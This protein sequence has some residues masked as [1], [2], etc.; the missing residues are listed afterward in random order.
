MT[1]S[2][3]QLLDELMRILNYDNLTDRQLRV[4]LFESS[5]RIKTL[6][7]ELVDGLEGRTIIDDFETEGASKIC[8]TIESL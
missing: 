7:E 4:K 8:K 2:A 1:M 3:D 5:L 6:K